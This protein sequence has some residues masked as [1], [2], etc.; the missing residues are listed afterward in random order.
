MARFTIF[1]TLLVI[2]MLCCAPSL[3]A[4]K[5]LNEKKGSVIMAGN[6]LQS[7]V[8]EGKS[9]PPSTRL[10]EKLFALHLAHLD[11][12]LQ[13]VPSPGAGH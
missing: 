10:S 13:S 6:V 9:T 8:L 7:A 11:R 2:V 12:I 5:L 1:V 4:R 3:D